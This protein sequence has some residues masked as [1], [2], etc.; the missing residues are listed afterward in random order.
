MS[1]AVLVVS[2]NGTQPGSTTDLTAQ[3]SASVLLLRP[4]IADYTGHVGFV[5]QADF[6][7]VSLAS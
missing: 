4:D 6:V 1:E 2:K 7:R 5:P 3:K